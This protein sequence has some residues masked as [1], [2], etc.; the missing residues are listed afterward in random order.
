MDTKHRF[1]LL[2]PQHG[3]APRD[4]INCNLSGLSFARPLIDYT[5]ADIGC[6]LPKLHAV[7]CVGVL[8][9]VTFLNLVEVTLI[10]LDRP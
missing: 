4:V 1:A 9:A 3:Q 6:V 7:V 5:A 10:Y 8:N 2:V